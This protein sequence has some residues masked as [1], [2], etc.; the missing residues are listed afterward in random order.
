MTGDNND[1]IVAQDDGDDAGVPL[2]DE[3][4]K[5]VAGGRPGGKPTTTTGKL[6]AADIVEGVNNDT[7]FAGSGS[8]EKGFNLGMPPTAK[9]PRKG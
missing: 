8:D 1:D 9:R 4:L 2:T 3:Q 5:G 6:L 7:L